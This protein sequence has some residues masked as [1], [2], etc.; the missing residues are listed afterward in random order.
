MKRRSP[1]WSRSASGA[2]SRTSP[3]STPAS[4]V[5]SPE[6]ARTRS[7]TPWP[8][9]RRS[10]KRSAR[11]TSER[12]R[13]CQRPPIRMN[14]SLAAASSASSSSVRTSSPTASRQSNR[15]SSAVERR[16]LDRTGGP[17]V[18]RRLTRRRLRVPSQ[19][20]GSMTGTPRS[21]S[22]GTALRRKRRTVV[23]LE[24]RL[25]RL[26]RMELDP[27][28]GEERL[29]LRQLPDQIAAR[30]AGTQ[31]REDLVAAA[32]EQRRG[33][34]ERRIV[35]RLQPQLEHDRVSVLRLRPR[36]LV[37][38]EAEPPRRRGASTEAGVDPARQPP[39]QRRVARVGRE[40]RL[41]G[42]E[43][44][45]EQLRGGRA[46]GPDGPASRTRS[47]WRRSRAI[48]STRTG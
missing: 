19:A 27:G 40:H 32:P 28:F 15:A 18:A 48:W 37:E 34:A 12:R 14:G 25:G 44:V 24:L 20:A 13:A 11:S 43:P 9:R 2:S 6:T 17:L 21:S 35:L 38:V 7:T 23:G 36:P 3:S 22:R 31:E 10:R 41:G 29:D 5:S 26:G 16:P 39:S 46:A 4:S 47:A 45:Q 30:V 1:P 8:A 42:G 33:Q